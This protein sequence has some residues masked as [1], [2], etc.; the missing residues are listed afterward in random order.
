MLTSFSHQCGACVRRNSV[1]ALNMKTLM[2]KRCVACIYSKT[3]CSLI[4]P[5]VPSSSSKRAPPGSNV[6]DSDVKEVLVPVAKGPKTPWPAKDISPSIKVKTRPSHVSHS[7]WLLSFLL[8]PLFLLVYCPPFFFIF[9][10]R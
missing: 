7:L 3:T 2:I 1:C 6:V 9:S 4:P 8:T 10:P 5:K